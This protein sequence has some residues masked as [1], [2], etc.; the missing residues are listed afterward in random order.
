LEI[1][2]EPSSSLL[3]A[4][5]DVAQ[6][7]QPVPALLRCRMKVFCVMWMIGRWK[8]ENQDRKEATVQ[9]LNLKII[10]KR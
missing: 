9:A 7:D 3:L 6:A 10:K 1:D 8:F 5:T 4:A 2:R